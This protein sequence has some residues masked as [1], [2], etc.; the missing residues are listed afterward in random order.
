M[1]AKE[2]AS[3]ERKKEDE[4]LEQENMLN[5]MT[6]KSS[7]ATT[8]QLTCGKCK[9]KKVSY[10]QAQTRSADEPLTTVSIAMLAYI[11]RHADSRLVLRM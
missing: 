9:N 11:E 10:S 8:D 7:K 6:A 2:L 1:T 3:E 5:A 4:A